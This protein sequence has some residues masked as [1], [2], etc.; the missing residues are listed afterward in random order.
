VRREEGLVRALIV[1]ECLVVLA[2]ATLILLRKEPGA[3]A[4][5]DVFPAARFLPDALPGEVATYRIDEG[6]G[7]L[8]FKLTAI[9]RGGPQGPPRA[10]IER[11]ARGPSGAALADTEPS[12]THFLTR[13]G[14]MPFLTPEDPG[15]LDRTWVLKRIRRV[16]IPWQGRPLACW[17]VECI[18]PG[19][20][21]DRDAIEVW[22]HEDVPVYGILRWQRAGRVYEFSSWRPRS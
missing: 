13:H 12:Y 21:P 7:T 5:A 10:Q 18:D 8:E 19:L 14:L 15:A 22:M 1:L 17:H 3:V 6:R 9:D 2:L 4:S 20:P 16:T 11:V